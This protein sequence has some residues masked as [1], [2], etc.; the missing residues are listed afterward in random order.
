[1][2]LARLATDEILDAAYTWLCARRRDY[3][4]NSDVWSFRRDWTLEKQRIRSDLLAGRYHFTLMDRVTLADGSDIDLWSSRDAL[5]LKALTI[6]LSDILPA[7]PRC[8]HVKGHGGAKSA[9]RQVYDHLPAKHLRVPH[10]CEV[11]LRV[12]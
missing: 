1:M 3:L 4:A 5:V 8:A 7:S 6:V 12:H 2:T 10:G 11:L 9:V